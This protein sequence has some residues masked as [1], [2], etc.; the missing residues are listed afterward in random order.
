MWVAVSFGCFPQHVPFFFEYLKEG[1]EKSGRRYYNGHV[2][3][4]MSSSG[5]RCYQTFATH[6]SA[7]AS[8]QDRG[9]SYH[10]SKRLPAKSQPEVLHDQG[11]PESIDEII[12]AAEIAA[13]KEKNMGIW[14]AIKAYPKAV[15][16]SMLLSTSL[17]MESYDLSLT[18]N[19]F[20][21]PQFRE[22]FGRRL[23]NG[24]YQLSSAWMSGLLNGTQVGQILGLMVAGI[25]AERY[26]YKKTI[27]GAMVALTGFIF[28]FFFARNIGM[29]MA[30]SML[31]GLPWGAFQTLTTTYAADVT[32]LALRPFLTTWVNMCWTIGFLI[33]AGVQ[34]GLLDR[35]D[36]WAW[37]IPYA[38][39]WVFLPPLILGIL[40]TPES[41]TW[42][43]RKGRLDD[44][45]RSL[46]NLTSRNVL[47]E[48]E[49]DQKVA[50]IAYE[51]KIER[52]IVAG[53]SYIDCFRGGSLRRTE[54][55]CFVWVAQVTCGKSWSGNAVYFLQQ[56]GLDPK[57]SFN[58]N[59]GI[60]GLALLG[61]IA[62]WFIM[63]K[64]G[65]RRLYLSG[66][67]ILLVLL[68]AIGFMGIPSPNQGIAWASGVFM[69]LSIALYDTTI[70]PAAYCLVTE[71]PSSRLRIKTVVL[72][73]NA[74]N[75]ASIGAN[76]LNAPMLNPTAWNL[77]GKGGFIWA[78]FCLVTLLWCYFRLPETRG[79]SQPEID[80]LFEKG[81]RARDFGS[82]QEEAF[83]RGQLGHQRGD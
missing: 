53:T 28:L 37:R 7:M 11:R 8:S 44:A 55:T 76:F 26:G 9:D 46:K 69:M 5:P 80:I 64:V 10:A 77:R 75:I 15:F 70:G 21:L 61:T 74:Y 45:R 78:A 6:P 39:Q 71:I 43:V 65:R 40:F 47:S 13:Q 3:L 19:F 31:C 52:E 38:I 36:D 59:I 73:R 30:A 50:L 34:R 56:V 49:V 48:D 33:G 2:Y 22:K 67:V 42:L 24:D 41:P 81:T 35:E 79:L 29:L 25:I 27:L 54:I 62:A 83:D 16:F 68:L 58:F 20:A 63:A 66:L 72:A 14:M 17:V 57:Q 18:R 4:A 1:K 23:E 12:S 60:S 51:D 32:P 82:V